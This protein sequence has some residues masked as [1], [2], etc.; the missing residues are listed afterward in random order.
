MAKK[1]ATSGTTRSTKSTKKTSPKK[2]S[3]KGAGNAPATG[4]DFASA[5]D[6]LEGA[7]GESRE[8]E[9]TNS[10]FA[11]PDVPDGDYI[12]QLIGGRVGAYKTGNRK[13]TVYVKFRY[14]IVIGE[15]TGEVLSSTDDVSTREVGSTGKTQ[16]DLLSE[17]LQ[18]MG[19]DT[20]KMSLKELPELV[21]WLTDPKKNSA[22]KPFFRVAVKNNFSEDDKG[23]TRHYQNV[24]VNEVLHPDA[25]EEMK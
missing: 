9:P 16:M 24:Y 25:V 17:R 15:F 23:E 13:G 19:I 3:P 1:K 5:I 2:T 14:N 8:K 21:L 4:V 18:R 11:P 7:W 12:V 20:K 6:G 10:G 22:A